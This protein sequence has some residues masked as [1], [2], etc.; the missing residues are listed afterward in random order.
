MEIKSVMI[1]FGT[2]RTRE[3][4]FKD[5]EVC[6]NDLGFNVESK[7][8]TRPW[9]GFF[10]LPEKQAE[11]FQQYFFAER[12]FDE[13]RGFPKLSPKILL[14][15]P[16]KR[17]SWQYHHRRAEIWKLVGGSA[18]VVISDTDEQTPPQDISLGGIIE[19]K[20]GE[21]HRLIGTQS[22]GMVAE[23]WKHT[24]PGH[25]SDESDIVRVQDDFGR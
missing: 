11:K 5:V 7:D 23:I 20:Q 2:E 15:A 10:V 3:D 12:N 14:V 18:G 25:P 17:L 1:D 22:W 24:I 8:M 4:L 19:L 9:G 6:L 13:F 21:R 16:E